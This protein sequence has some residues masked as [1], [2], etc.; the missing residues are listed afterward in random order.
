MSQYFMRRLLT[1]IPVL[2]GVLVVTFIII[3]LTPGDPARMV[4]GMDADAATVAAIREQLGLNR[5]VPLQFVS[6]VGNVL[7]GDFGRSFHTGELVRNEIAWR[8]ANTL[9]LAVVGVSVATIIGIVTGGI[10]A[11]FPH[12]WL[13]SLAMMVALIG[14]SA[15]VFWIGLVFM[16]VFGV[17]LR[18]LP[19]GGSGTWQHLVL[20]ALTLGLALAG[21]I[22]RMTRSSLLE[23]L[24][25]D[26]IRT[27]KAY[28]FSA[29]VLVFRYALRNAILPVITVVGL[30]LGY[31]LA[32]AVL[33]ETV[34][35]WPGLGR[36]V[37]GSIFTRDYPVIQAGLLLVAFTF[38]F[39]NFIVDMLYAIIDPRIRFD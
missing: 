31:S 6:Y 37:V 21:M 19:T 14:I 30:Q 38:A 2:V 23:V 13:D 36:L 24:G 35:A 16:Y 27:S 8:Y 20:P 11:R 10:S 5:P 25:Q 9:L 4:A 7:R 15:P 17:Q 12:S 3:H 22:A 29:N 34:F 1:L 26:Y 18:V 28:G 33:T 39:V 32:G